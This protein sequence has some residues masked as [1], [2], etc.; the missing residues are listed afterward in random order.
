MYRLPSHVKEE[1]LN[2]ELERL[3]YESDEDDAV[4]EYLYAMLKGEE[5]EESLVGESELL[6]ARVQEESRLEELCAKTRE[7][8]ER[9]LEARLAAVRSFVVP[10]GETGSE[11]PGGSVPEMISAE[12]MYDETDDWCC[13]MQRWNAMGVKMKIDSV[14]NVFSRPIVVSLQITRRVAIRAE[15]TKKG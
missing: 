6:L 15:S 12:E 14:K 1:E 4:D 3:F 7:A 5:L 10:E 2:E 11:R 9:R 8:E 13:R